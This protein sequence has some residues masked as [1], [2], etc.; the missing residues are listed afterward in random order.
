[1]SILK[2][3]GKTVAST[4]TGMNTRNGGGEENR[5]KFKDEPKEPR[6]E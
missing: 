1:M 4:D 2:N 3:V 5:Q 6:I